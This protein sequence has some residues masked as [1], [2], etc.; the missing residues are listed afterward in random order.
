MTEARRR[1]YKR[2][3]SFNTCVLPV[4]DIEEC[5]Q[6]LE[7]LKLDKFEARHSNYKTNSCTVTNELVIDKI[8][9]IIFPEFYRQCGFIKGD[10]FLLDLFCIKYDKQFKLLE[11][12][13]D[14]CLLSFNILLN[15]PGEFIGGGTKFT[16]SGKVVHIKQGEAVMHC[17]KEEHEGAE[18]LDG[19]RWVI[20]GFVETKRLGP[21]SKEY[22]FNLS[23]EKDNIANKLS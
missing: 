18:I 16:Q 1:E 15:D 22:H 2:H 12:H 10:L 7:L 11:S 17:S 20:V 6:L 5:S 19:E 14:G 3:G 8:N 23:R 9:S 4:L 21:Y 13:T